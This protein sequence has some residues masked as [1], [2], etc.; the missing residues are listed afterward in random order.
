MLNLMINDN[1]MIDDWSQKKQ[2][3]TLG[4]LSHIE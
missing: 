1:L 4:R 3:L 2:W